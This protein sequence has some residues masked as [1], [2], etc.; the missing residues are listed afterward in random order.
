MAEVLEPRD[1]QDLLEMV[2]AAVAES[3]PL[4]IEGTGSKRAFGRPVAAVARLSLRRLS[5]ILLYEPAE[6]VMTVRAGTPRAEVERVLAERRQQLAFEPA[7]YGRILGGSGGGETMGGLFAVDAA[8]PRRVRMGS[9][10]DH[11]LGMRA[12][13]GFATVIRAGGR[14]M[15]NVTGYDITKLYCHAFGTLVVA[16]EL[17]FKVLPAPET[18]ATLVVRGRDEAGLL[19]LAARALGT[20]CEVSGAAVLPAL[21]AGR[22]EVA[23][24]RAPGVPVALLRLE[25]APPSVDVRLGRLQR[26]LAAPDLAFE[27]VAAEPSRRL[28]QEIRDVALL[29]AGRPLWRFTLAPSRAAELAPWFAEVAEERLYD[30]AGGLVWLA[31]RQCW[32][33][34]GARLRRAL[35]GRGGHAILVRAPEEVRAAEQVFPPLPDPLFRLTRRVKEAFDPERILNRGRMYA[36]L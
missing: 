2:A 21:A 26:L 20:P 31:P 17:T 27:T 18:A 11:L 23:A 3:R 34:D 5:G 8:G 24:V 36:E 33:G 29:P 9:A 13:T 22:S 10:R 12:V 1:E 28:W 25:G 6:L 4:E 14:V 32:A 35:E 15:K 30:Q 7:D 16:T 19:R